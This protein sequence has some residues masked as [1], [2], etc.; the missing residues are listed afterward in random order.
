MRSFQ[1]LLFFVCL[2][3]FP[4][5]LFASDKTKPHGHRGLLEVYDGKPLPLHITNDQSKKLDNG[6]PVRI[7]EFAFLLT[8]CSNIYALT[9]MRTGGLQ[10]THWQVWSWCGHPGRECHH[11]HLHG[12]DPRLGQLQQDGSS[13]EECQYLRLCQVWQCKRLSIFTDKL[14]LISVCY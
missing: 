1:I 8:F 14:P 13:C 12:Q 2:A 4:H 9:L 11:W 7:S 3:Y 5:V 10:W 6:D